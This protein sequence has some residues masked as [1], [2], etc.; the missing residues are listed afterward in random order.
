MTLPSGP[1][2]TICPTE[3]NVICASHLAYLVDLD[4]E[5]SS[6]AYNASTN[7]VHTVISKLA[8][9]KDQKQ[10]LTIAEIDHSINVFEEGSSTLMGTLRTENEILEADLWTVGHHPK[11]KAQ[12]LSVRMTQPEQTLAA[13]NK[14]GVL[15]LFPEPFDFSA[16]SSG[17]NTDSLKARMKHRSRPSTAQVKILRPGKS[18]EQVP[19]IA[20]S[21]LDN[22]IVM[23]WVEG[24]V[25]VLFETLKWREEETRFLLLRGTIDIVQH[26][27]GAGLEAVTMNGAK[28]M[29][30]SHVDDSH[31]VVAD[32]ADADDVS[33][34]E[35][36]QDVIDIS[37][38]EETSDFEEDEPVTKPLGV[39]KDAAIEE[40][41]EQGR[42]FV[43]EEDEIMGDA[44]GQ[45]EPVEQEVGSPTFG[46]LIRANA[47]DPIDV[48]THLPDNHAQSLVPANPTSLQP[49]SSGLSLGTVLTQALRTNDTNL[50]ETCFHTQDL[51]TVRATIER[52]ESSFATALL[53]RLAERLHSRPG[54]AGSLMVWIQWTLV[55]HGGYLAGQPE[56][57]RKLRSL[58]KVV[59]ER[60]GSLQSLLSLKGKLD[61]LEAQMNLRRSVL[62]RGRGGNV[63]DEEEDEDA[64][65]YVEGQEEEDDDDDEEEEEDLD[66]E[67]E[68]DGSDVD[69][70]PGAMK[71]L[72]PGTT[73]SR[74]SYETGTRRKKIGAKNH[75]NSEGGAEEEEEQQEDAMPPTTNGH[76]IETDSDSEEEEEGDILDNE[77]SSA[78]DQNTS[79][80]LDAGDEEIDHDSVDDISSSDDDDDDKGRETNPP[81]PPSRVQPAPSGN[82]KGKGKAKLSNGI[83][84]TSS[85]EKKKKKKRR[86]Q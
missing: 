39:Q 68:D 77:A 29:G 66:S 78:S 30:R 60:A 62:E 37:S 16:A 51:S 64:V 33:M 83:I 81:S 49:L 44:G 54:R 63:D 46:D 38:A 12:D 61:M 76:V 6:A 79:D 45:E 17:Q 9:P 28:D 13:L 19:L 7:T 65:I 22:Y 10:F 50:L 71:T 26:K 23:A 57:M 21:F 70:E 80:E 35:M 5:E 74:R 31:A 84:N 20:A 15:E 41:V 58:H 3:F 85:K 82:A 86:N 14:D 73:R 43:D 32:G 11:D 42:N 69:G 48:A 27:T 8:R 25:K 2:N 56:M 59:R 18:A 53:Q 67:E 34:N 72:N 24:G 47:S 52:L 4:L 36:D 40:Q 75:T 55:A 1:A